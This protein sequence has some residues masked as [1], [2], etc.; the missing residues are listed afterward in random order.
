MTHLTGPNDDQS[1]DL[2]PSPDH[3]AP[4]R[5]VRISA[6]GVLFG[7]MFLFGI[8]TAAL[9]VLNPGPGQPPAA[10]G[11]T[12]GYIPPSVL[13]KPA[14]DVE[15]RALDGSV[16]HLSDYQ[17]KTIFLNFWWTGCAPCIQELPDLE[18]FAQAHADK[19]VVVLG[20]TNMD[21]PER[22][23]TFLK[24]NRITLDK[25]VVLRD[26]A[27]TSYDAT[28]QMG[29]SVYPT[30]WVIEPD[31]NVKKV[32]FGVLTAEEMDSY[33]SEVRQSS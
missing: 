31:L 8:V 32:K 19:G 11:S 7:M 13:N 20:V 28:R 17:G 25:V 15:L 27:D 26:V 12:A 23:D 24:E 9:I 22:I 4:P 2:T 16:V 5:T 30:T 29:V 10:T 3:P 21:T 33:L 1:P 14:P 18:A 6:A